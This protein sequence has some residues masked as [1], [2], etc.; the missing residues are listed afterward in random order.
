MPE[1]SQ[2][3]TCSPKPSRDLP[4]PTTPEPRKGWGKTA[5]SLLSQILSRLPAPRLSGP[6]GRRCYSA[7]TK[8][9]SRDCPW[10][11]WPW[12]KAPNTSAFQTHCMDQHLTS[13]PLGFSCTKVSGVLVQENRLH[14]KGEYFTSTVLD[15]T[16]LQLTKVCKTYACK[17]NSLQGGFVAYFPQCI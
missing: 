3:G 14:L 10:S 4:R 16:P 7:A 15:Q 11:K 1:V 5:P 6:R 12:P 2:W 8:R 9:Q 17:K 13:Y